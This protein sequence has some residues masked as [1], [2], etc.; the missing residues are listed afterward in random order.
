[1][2]GSTV[3]VTELETVRTGTPPFRVE[4]R[5]GTLVAIDAASGSIKWTYRVPEHLTQ[6]A[7]ASDGTVY[8]ATFEG[9]GYALRGDGTLKWV[10]ALGSRGSE[11]GRSDAAPVVAADGTVYVSSFFNPG[12]GNF[13]FALATDGSTKWKHT[14]LSIGRHGFRN[15]AERGFG[16]I[17]LSNDGA[18]YVIAKVFGRSEGAGEGMR[19]KLMRVY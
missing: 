3:F 14:W 4:T 12:L 13:V 18:I 19:S 6:P 2:S 7:V 16:A 1:V 9:G 10:S 11:S 17:S 8:F 15:S 5:S